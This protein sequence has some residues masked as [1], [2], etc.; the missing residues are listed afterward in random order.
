M[1]PRLDGE[2][3]ALLTSPSRGGPGKRYFGG[4]ERT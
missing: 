2:P 1:R 3:P 4:N